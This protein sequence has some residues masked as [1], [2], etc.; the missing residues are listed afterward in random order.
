[1]SLSFTDSIDDRSHD[2]SVIKKIMI[3]INMVFY[4][5]FSALLPFTQNKKRIIIH[6]VT[7]IQTSKI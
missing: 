2:N 3:P 6:N 4:L 1:M 7:E 5:S